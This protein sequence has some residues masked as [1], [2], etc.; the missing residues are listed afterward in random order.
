MTRLRIDPNVRLD[1]GRTYVGFE[2]VLTY[3]VP[4]AGD[5]VEVIEPESGI[6]GYATV[7]RVNVGA[8]LIYLLIDWD[9]LSTEPS[10]AYT[11]AAQRKTLTTGHTPGSWMLLLEV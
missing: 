3:E 7:E 9:K 6:V 5:W 4:R 2:D 11:G 8:R 10:V 1:G